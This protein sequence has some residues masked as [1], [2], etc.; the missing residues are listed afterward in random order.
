MP[1]GKAQK[2]RKLLISE[3][4]KAQIPLR[5]SAMIWQNS[6]RTITPFAVKQIIDEIDS[7]LKLHPQHRVALPE[8]QFVPEQADHFEHIAI[9]N[10]LLANFNQ[11]HDFNRYLL[12]KTGPGY[13]IAD[14]TRYLNV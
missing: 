2:L 7:T 5:I 12:L 8:C 9:I 14:K 6:I 4:R 11:Q 1:E 13:H 10:L 3:I